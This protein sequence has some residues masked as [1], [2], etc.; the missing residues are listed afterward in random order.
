MSAF[1]DIKVFMDDV[2]FKEDTRWLGTHPSAKTSF[3]CPSDDVPSG[4]G[5]THVGESTRR[6]WLV[7]VVV[8]VPNDVYTDLA[9]RDV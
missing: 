7:R 5:A 9:M 6:P 4:R 3:Q 2:F 1:P 8:Y